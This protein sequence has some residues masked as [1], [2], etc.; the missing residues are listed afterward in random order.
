M[1][2]PTRGSRDDDEFMAYIG[3]VFSIIADAEEENLWLF[4][5]FNCASDSESYA[6]LVEEWVIL[7]AR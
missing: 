5:D 4:R 3:K 2:L 7:F 6:N 1:F